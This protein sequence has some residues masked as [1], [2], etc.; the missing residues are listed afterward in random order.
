MYDQV[1]KHYTRAGQLMLAAGFFNVLACIAIG[2]VSLF[3]VLY[4]YGIGACCCLIP[5]LSLW[6]G[7]AELITGIRMI[8]GKPTLFAKNVSALGVILGT[9][10]LIMIP[11][12]LEILAFVFLSRPEVEGWLAAHD[13]ELADGGG[14]DWP[15]R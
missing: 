1:P 3:T 15:P 9:M 13:P 14:R 7:I 10:S 4:T 6:A 8:Q 2:L 11:T 5:L 12:F